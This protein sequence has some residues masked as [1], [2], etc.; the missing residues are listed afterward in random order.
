M[1]IL[2]YN[3]CN[4]PDCDCGWNLTLSGNDNK[5]LA[6]VKAFVKSFNNKLE[7][8]TDYAKKINQEKF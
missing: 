8:K 6:I 5:E 4:L 2:D 1:N 7:D 3:R